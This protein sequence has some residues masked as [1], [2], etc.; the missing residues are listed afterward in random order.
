MSAVEVK[1]SPKSPVPPHVPPE[2]V[3]DYDHIFTPTEYGDLHDY[4]M[5]LM[6]D[7]PPIFWTPRNGGHWVSARHQ[8]V[9]DMARNTEVFS[10]RSMQLGNPHQKVVMLPINLDPPEHTKYRAPLIPAFAPKSVQAI[11]QSVRDLTN[12]LIDKVLALGACEFQNAVA[13]PL[14]ITIFMRMMGM[15]LERMGEF[16][17]WVSAAFSTS[18]P[19]VQQVYFDKMA[20]AMGELIQLRMKK[21]EDDLISRMLDAKIDDR[22]PT[23]EEMVN[24]ALLLFVAGLDTVVNGMCWGIR[25]LARDAEL[26]ERLRADASLIPQAVEEL[27]RRYQVTAVPR[28]IAKDFVY[29][30]VQFMKDDTLLMLL[31]AANLD[32]AVFPDPAT[33]DIGRTTPHL[34]FGAGPHRCIGSH[35]ARLEIRVLYEEW[36]RRVPSFRLDPERPARFHAGTVYTVM[37]LP[38]LWTPPSA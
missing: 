22:P 25:H 4:V 8:T 13:E 37:S 34:A 2:L 9:S 30:G 11:E 12:Q 17:E 1:L 10:S 23:F 14:P 7:A 6:K 38:L 19:A 33:V 31:P 21:R 27:L 28:V 26:Q 20:G 29:E 35:L 16:R 18:D 5:H 36:L 15:P 32:P 24:Y 3:Y